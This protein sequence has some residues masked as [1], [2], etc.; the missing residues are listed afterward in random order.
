MAFIHIL[1]ECKGSLHGTFATYPCVVA[2][3]GS[4]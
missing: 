4:Q 1:A 3:E 2:V